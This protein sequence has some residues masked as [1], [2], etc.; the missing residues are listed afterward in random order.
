MLEYAAQSVLRLKIL[1]PNA[2]KRRGD[3]KMTSNESSSFPRFLTSN[4]MLSQTV[5]PRLMLEAVHF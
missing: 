2:S 3:Q 4:L 1:D 5:F